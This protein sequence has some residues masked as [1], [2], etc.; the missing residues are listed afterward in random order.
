MQ[1]AICG[2]TPNDT[3]WD[4]VTLSFS[5]K[6]L[7]PSLQPPTVS[8]VDSI[9]RRSR[10]QREQ[11]IIAQP[12]TRKALR[13]VVTGRSLVIRAEELKKRANPTLGSDEMA[14]DIVTEGEDII[15]G[16][17]LGP[18]AADDLLERIKAIP[19]V[20]EE[21]KKVNLDLAV[22]FT[23]HYGP[24]AILEGHEVPEAYRRFFVQVSIFF[25]SVCLVF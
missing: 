14:Q 19:V 21:L 24:S 16:T 8:H 7:L 23:E 2:P 3:I 13:K 6:H 9:T 12:T 18:K 11:Q 4:G 10:Y 15:G 20:Y 5:R 25:E 17:I 22:I 1:C